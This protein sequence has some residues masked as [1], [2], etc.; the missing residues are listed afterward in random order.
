MVLTAAQ[1]RAEPIPPVRRWLAARPPLARLHDCVRRR[2]RG[3]L[4]VGLAGGGQRLLSTLGILESCQELLRVTRNYYELLRIIKFLV[5][6]T[7]IL[8]GF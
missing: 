3:S 5:G 8:K 6:F 4:G 2:L 7:M 1:L